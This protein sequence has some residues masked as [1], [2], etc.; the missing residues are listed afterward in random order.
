MNLLLTSL[1]I[2]FHF[3]R[4][5]HSVNLA[6]G[7]VYAISF[8]IRNSGVFL[9]CSCAGKTSIPSSVGHQKSTDDLELQP[10]TVNE[11][12]VKHEKRV[13]NVN[14]PNIQTKSGLLQH[15]LRKRCWSIGL[16]MVSI[17]TFSEVAWQFSAT[18]RKMNL[19]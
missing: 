11:G 14:V 5:R 6:E 13:Y 16:K 12:I 4:K 15:V 9:P 2:C 18:N 19:F 17:P 10:R 1:R 7:T 8:P 3:S